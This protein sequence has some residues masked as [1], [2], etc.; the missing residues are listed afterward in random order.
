MEVPAVCS[1]GR[2]NE[3]LYTNVVESDARLIT[4]ATLP[5]RQWSVDALSEIA[6]KR[7]NAPARSL[8]TCRRRKLLVRTRRRHMSGHQSRAVAIRCRRR[9][10]CCCCCCCCCCW[11]MMR[12]LNIRVRIDID[13]GQRHRARVL[14]L[15]AVSAAQNE[16]PS[17]KV[18]LTRTL[19]QTIIQQRL[20]GNQRGAMPQNFGGT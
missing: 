17:P 4:V 13:D 14:R 2:R 16:I 8:P 10:L 7:A 5:P 3:M 11:R 9:R 12:S 6:P 18:I 15:R 20:H 19:I 1:H